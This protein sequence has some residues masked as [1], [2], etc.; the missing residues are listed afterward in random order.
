MPRRVNSSRFASDLA[1]RLPIPIFH[2]N[3][4]DADAVVRVARMAAE[5]RYA[6]GTDVV[7]DLIGYR[8]H[9]HSEVDDPTDHPAAAATARSRSTRRSG[10][11]T[12]SE[13]GVDPSPAGVEQFSTSSTP[14]RSSA[15]KIDARSRSCASSRLTGT[16]IVGG[17]YKPEY[18]VDTGLSR[19]TNCRSSPTRLTSYP[20]GFHI[21]PKVK[22]LLEQR[23]EMG[24]GKRAVDYGM[25]EALAFGSLREAGHARA[26]QRAG[27]PARHLQPAPLAC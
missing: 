18:E 11:S 26:P 14:R 2:V 8:R 6:F 13:I 3:G 16:P 19:R 23:A 9:G 7:V 4:E 12:P 27:Q 25:A 5:Y 17:R 21:H 22:K 20:D 10:R 15:A 1:K 24:D